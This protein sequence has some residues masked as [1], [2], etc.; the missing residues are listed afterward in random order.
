MK[1]TP[2]NY[3]FR[4]I[5]QAT[6]FRAVYECLAAGFIPAVYGETLDGKFKTQPRIAD[7]IKL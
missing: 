2:A 5:G 4:L 1:T 6:V 3:T 7:I